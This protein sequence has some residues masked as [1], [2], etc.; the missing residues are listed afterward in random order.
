LEP[1][2][3]RAGMLTPAA[4]KAERLDT[5]LA[6]GFDPGPVRVV[7][8]TV[9]VPAAVA[10]DLALMGPSGVH[11]DRTGVER[12]LGAGDGPIRVHVEVRAFRRSL[13]E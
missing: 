4:D 10:A 6:A 9:M 12:D 7:D 11:L 1:L 3:T 2:R 13:Q 8:V 5:D